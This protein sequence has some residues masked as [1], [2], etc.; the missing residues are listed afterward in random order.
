MISVYKCKKKIVIN[1]NMFYSSFSTTTTKVRSSIR[2]GIK[3]R[4]SLISDENKF[5][6]LNY[7]NKII[8]NND[9][10]KFL[11]SELNQIDIIENY[12]KKCNLKNELNRLKFRF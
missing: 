2:K 12:A 9:C 1:P 3:K 7:L 5:D 10:L 6:K 8:K 11:R 4:L